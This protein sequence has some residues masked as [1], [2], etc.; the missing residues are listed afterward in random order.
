MTIRPAVMTGGDREERL[1]TNASVIDKR[2]Q[3]VRHNTVPSI[4]R[5]K[6]LL[7][8]GRLWACQDLNLGPHPYQRWTVKRRANEH[9]PRRY[10]SVSAIGMG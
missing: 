2:T 9:S 1:E 3:E 7:V 4:R 8:T 6:R 10:G 5:V